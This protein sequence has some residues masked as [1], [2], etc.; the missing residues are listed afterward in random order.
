[1]EIGRRYEYDPDFLPVL[2]KWLDLKPGMLA[3]DVG[4]GS[5][6]FT[7]ILAR[8]LKGMGKVVGIDPDKTLILEAEKITKKE[9]LLNIEFKVGSIYKIPL[10]DNYADLIAC[11]IVLYCVTFPD[12]LTL[13]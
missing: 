9:G 8:G 13:F 7:R 1:M 5:G 11:H 3:V 6:Y 4:C 10:P 2:Y 12:N